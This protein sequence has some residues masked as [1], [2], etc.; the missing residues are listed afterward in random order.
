M[1]IKTNYIYQIV[2]LPTHYVFVRVFLFLSRSLLRSSSYHRT[3]ERERESEREGYRD[4][5]MATNGIEVTAM[6]FAYDGQPQVFS[7][8][9]LNIAPGSRCLLIGANGSGNPNSRMNSGFSRF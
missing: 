4:P 7:R 1:F 6:N 9:T 5:E 3:R 8:F 2:K